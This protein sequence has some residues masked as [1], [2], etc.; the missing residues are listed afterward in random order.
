M[1]FKDR[2]PK[3][4]I[5][6]IVLAAMIYI[7]ILTYLPPPKAYREAEERGYERGYEDGRSESYDEGWNDGYRSGYA[8]GRAGDK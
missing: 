8:D 5:A 2:H 3:L 1:K 4:F 7:F 6:L